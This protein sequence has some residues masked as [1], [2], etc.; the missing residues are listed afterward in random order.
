MLNLSPS[1]IY[2]L[3]FIINNIIISPYLKSSNIGIIVDYN[4][5]F[6][7]HVTVITKYYNSNISRIINK[8]S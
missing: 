2:S 8:S 4:F 7:T 3:H 5:S 6:I 1:P